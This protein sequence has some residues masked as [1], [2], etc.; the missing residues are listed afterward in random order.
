MK[1]LDDLTPRQ[2]EL[3]KE[4]LP[5]LETLDAARLEAALGLM[6]DGRALEMLEQLATDPVVAMAL[7]TDLLVE[8]T[9]DMI[10]VLRRYDDAQV[11]H[12]LAV[13]RGAS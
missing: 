5:E 10:N 9:R 2:R 1:T 3:V 13:V 6:A 7:G 4:Y 11:E 12:A 8:M